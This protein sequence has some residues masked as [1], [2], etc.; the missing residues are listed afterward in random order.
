MPARKYCAN[1][2]PPGDSAPPSNDPKIT[3]ITSG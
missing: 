3:I 2:T 1:G